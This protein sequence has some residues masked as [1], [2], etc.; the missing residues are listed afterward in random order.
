MENTKVVDDDEDLKV[1][2]SK[3]ILKY[4]LLMFTV[5]VILKICFSQFCAVL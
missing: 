1:P 4:S 2:L 3:P 5:F